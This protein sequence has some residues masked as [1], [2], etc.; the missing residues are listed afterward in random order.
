[1]IIEVAAF[2]GDPPE[3]GASAILRFNKSLDLHPEPGA[4]LQATATEA[5]AALLLALDEARAHLLE[6]ARRMGLALEGS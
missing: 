3:Q 5:A 4:E 1:M 6:Q 2:A